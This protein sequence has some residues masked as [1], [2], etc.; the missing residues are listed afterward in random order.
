M[1]FLKTNDIHRATRL[2]ILCM[3][4]ASLLLS[5]CKEDE[6]TFQPSI[7]S[8]AFSFRPIAG[9]SIMH[10]Q[11]PADKEIVGINIR[12]KNF[13]GKEILRT[14]SVLSD[15]ISLIGFNEAKENVD[16]E[17]RLVKRNGEE[18]T[19]IAV[20]FSTE[21]SAPWAF[22][23]KVQV[24]S[25]WNGFSITTDNPQNATGMAHVFYLGTDPLTGQ[26]DTVLIN[27]F[28]LEEGKDTL[29]F[30]VK[31][32][33]DVNTIVIRTEDFSGYMVKEQ[34]FPNIAS[35][36]TQKLDKSNFDFYCDKSIE[37]EEGMLGQKYLF[38]GDKKAVNYY[39]DSDKDHFRTFMAGPEAIGVP[40]YI[41]MRKNLLTAQ[42]SLYAWA[43]LRRTLGSYSSKYSIMWNYCYDNKLPCDIDVYAAK[44]DGEGASNWDSKEWIKLMSYKQ[45]PD[46]EES[47]RWCAKAF[48]NYDYSYSTKDQLEKADSV[49]LNITFPADGQ[50][51]GYRYLKIIVNKTYNSMVSGWNTTRYSNINNYITFHELELYTKEE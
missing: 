13:C 42:I 4:T 10:Y 36:N 11:L 44:D 32:K 40:M 37:D 29:T 49:P 47:S 48:R 5:A 27:S 14:A 30:N 16:A 3:A 8:E 51:E 26:P 41:D 23:D 20:K 39:I 38:D 9:G 17:V 43:N 2:L 7:S 21:D 46:I 34:V 18:S 28:Y 15:S 50:G 24:K 31:Q 19:P 12:Y 33:R 22:F 1:R 6:N 25:G 45:D 35:Y